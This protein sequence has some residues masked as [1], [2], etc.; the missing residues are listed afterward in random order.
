MA[1][2]LSTPST[3][4]C[5]PVLGMM[6]SV[7]RLKPMSMSCTN[8]VA[9][10]GCLA[11]RSRPARADDRMIDGEQPEAVGMFVGSEE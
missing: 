6:R 11:N 3:S 4:F 2:L 7:K 5:S 1:I 10:Y 8:L 9:L